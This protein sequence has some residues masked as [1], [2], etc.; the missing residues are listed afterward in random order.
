M[1]AK[2]A[3]PL[4]VTFLLEDLDFGGT[5][6]QTLELAARL[7][8]ERFS[9]R[10]VTLRRGGMH[11]AGKAETLKLPWLALSDDAGEINLL[12]SLPALWRYLR[13]ERPPLLQLLTVLPNIWGRVMGA[14]L[15]L[16]GIIG[17][18]R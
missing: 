10:L 8:R 6:S 1:K 12:R 14:G 4:P 13:R 7:D 17:C 15:R 3:G 2:G 5:Q 16:P 18:C 11:L 9:P